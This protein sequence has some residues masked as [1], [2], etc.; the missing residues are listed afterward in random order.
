MFQVGFSK[1]DL[2]AALQ[3][4]MTVREERIEAIGLYLAD[5]HLQSIWVTLDF[6]DFDLNVVNTLTDAIHKATGIDPE[7][8]HI[9]TTHNHGGGEPDLL[10]L[11]QLTA[12]CAKNA[13]ENAKPAQMRW[14]RCQTDRQVNII[15]RYPVP[16][17]G[18]MNTMYYGATEEN[19]FNCAPFAEQAVQS[20]KEG[21]LCYSGQRETARSPMAL[22]VGDPDV[23]SLQFRDPSGSILG[24]VVRFAAHAVCCNLDDSYSS[25]YPY[26]V[27][28]GIEQAFGGICIFWNGPCGDIAP[29]MTAKA[30]GTE[31]KL[32]NYI[33]ELASNA[34][35]SIS[36]LP[37][38]SFKDT[39]V[40]VFLPV[41]NELRNGMPA[42]PEA[43]PEA[44]PQ[45]RQY[46]E[47]RLLIELAD[48]LQRKYRNGE[49]SP[50]DTICASLGFLQLNDL[51]FAA[52]PGETFS[53]TG[54]ALQKAFPKKEICTITEH[55]RTVMYL[56]PQTDHSLGGYESVCRTTAADAERYLRNAA[57][58]AVAEISDQLL[59]VTE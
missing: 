40:P 27:R 47:Q 21:R 8:I 59:G 20:V 54:K 44:I 9:V 13:V 29:C 14:A 34:L 33:S 42:L 50:A 32:G 18:G 35:N 4:K 58:N 10:S 36:F 55:G 39:S 45:R 48:F 31:K 15:R 57:Q 11:S 49:K 22:P 56:P 46:L 5:E 53:V 24:T 3:P 19:G 1:Q 28:K 12:L 25:D 38:T 26:H 7:N 30:D 17:F 2:E 23:V 41:R 16:E 6:M 51:L 52:F 37:I 43:I